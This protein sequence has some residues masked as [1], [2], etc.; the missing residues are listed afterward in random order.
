MTYEA[1]K[2]L[3]KGS[4]VRLIQD[5]TPGIVTEAIHTGQ[6]ITHSVRT[7]RARVWI[8][9]EWENGEKGYLDQDDCELIEMI[10]PDQA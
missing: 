3:K 2:G 5:H 1:F 6:V 10:N 8:K 9:V 4:R 7:R